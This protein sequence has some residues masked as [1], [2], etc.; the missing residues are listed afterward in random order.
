MYASTSGRC[1]SAAKRKPHRPGLAPALGLR[2]GSITLTAD[3]IAKE[4]LMLSRLCRRM[5]RAPVASTS[6]RPSYRLTVEALEG[7]CLLS[8]D[9]VLRWNEAL[10]AAMRTAGQGLVS[11][12]SAAIVQTAVYE[13]VNAIDGSYIPYLVNIPAPPWASEEAAAAEA[14]HDALVGLFPAQKPV[15]DL[16]LKASLQDIPDG[17]AK[18]SGIQVGHAAAQ[19]LLAVRAHDGWDRVVNYTPGTNPGDWQPTPPAFGPPVA[20][21]W[22]SVTPFALQ[23]ASQFRPPP[24]PALTSPEYTAAFNQVKDLGAF[25]SPTRTADQTEAAMFWQGVVGPNVVATENWNQ[26]AQRV[27]V[28]Q[29]NTLVGNA[30]LFAL[31]NLAL[32]DAAIACWDAKY[33]YNFWR[34]VTAIRAADT[35]GNPDTEADP[36]WTPLL[37]TPSHPSYPSAHA[38]FSGGCAEVLASYFGTDDIPFTYSWVGLPGVT[39]SFAGF[40][41]A[42]TE[43]GMSRIWAGFHWSFDV[44]AGEA[45]GQSVGDYVFQN[46]LLPVGGA[47]RGG[48][49]GRTH[50]A[51]RGVPVPAGLA[52]AAPFVLLGGLGGLPTVSVVDTAIPHDQA[53]GGDGDTRDNGVHAASGTL[54]LGASTSHRNRARGDDGDEGGADGIGVGGVV[55]NLGTTLF[56]LATVIAHNHAAT[57]NDDC[58]GC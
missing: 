58:F 25:D 27:A 12:R 52:S 43:I 51:G 57:S 46:F 33:T 53:V 23:S 37:A 2:A 5:A 35:D 31:M 48:A 18:T 32:A 17:D 29:G 49:A 7:R 38:S 15:L 40:S 28:A 9:M 54:T 45:L 11:T 19:I 4:S 39:R 22:G 10:L 13:A 50:E 30:R 55:Y 14:A 6:L 44:T 24:P 42:L 56:D 1:V 16:E 26:I 36:N 20:P 34:P 8:G 21:Q 3:Q 47:P 41:A